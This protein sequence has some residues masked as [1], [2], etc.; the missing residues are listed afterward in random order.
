MKT[1]INIIPA[2][3]L[4]G[5]A[6]F[7]LAPVARAVSPAPDG[8]Y[9]GNNTAEGTLALFSRTTGIND[10]ALGFQ[11]LYHNTTGNYN[12][13]E[14]FRA[15]FT[16]TTGAVNTATGV[17]AL[18]SNSI[19]N[20]NTANGGNALYRNTSG[21]Q[22]TAIGVN[23]LFSTS[24][25]RYNTANGV[26]ALFHNT[27]GILNTAV[28]VGSL[29]NN[30]SG[31]G[32]IALG[33]N[34]G[35]NVTGSN[36]IAIGH[37]G[38]AGESGV[39]RIGTEGV[40]TDMFP[41][42]N[43]HIGSGPDAAF[44]IEP[45][46]GS[47]N[48]GYIR[49]GD[50]TGWRLHFGRSRQFSGGP[51]NTGTSGTLMTL[52]DNGNVGIGTLGL[53][54]APRTRLHVV[55]SSGSP[56]TPAGHIVFIQQNGGG[57]TAGLAIQTPVLGGALLLGDNFITFFDGNGTSVGAI[58]GNGSGSVQ[59]GGAGHD[60][61]EYLPK[62]DPAEEIVAAQVV[63]VRNGRIVSRGAAA[64][65]YMVVT[66]QA[67]VA[68]NRPSEDP[69]D[70]AKRSLVAFTGQVRVQVR[71][72]V[73]TGDFIVAS[74]NGDGTGVA[75][76]A[77]EIPPSAMHRVVGRAWESSSSEGLKTINVAVG[78]DQTSLAVPM[79]ERLACEN[80]ELRAANAALE[81]KLSD[82]DEKLTA[83]EARDQAREARL[84]RFENALA[85]RFAH[86]VTD[87]VA[88]RK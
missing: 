46:D 60:Y 5:I 79:L 21:V 50:N 53:V 52:Q 33:G 56:A 44:R 87:A 23:A 65:Q 7:A 26:N 3:M 69:T 14:G 19:G 4:F 88:D 27:T 34:A 83:L 61:A 35:L 45:S 80:K 59:L 73:K 43:I 1:N 30:S 68:G 2:L 20:Y 71:G 67:I 78:L 85:N 84:T 57:T 12:S 18:F 54:G 66:G 72:Q 22:N 38:I 31:S 17:N 49:F 55:G 10:T 36:N 64:D 41:A 29:L 13:A 48:A 40:H 75:M 16:N 74:E 32:N 77:A 47:P 24:T 9:P 76:A 58:E 63:G 37:A 86:S 15:L 70:L 42:G 62:E 11:A 39:I 25:G 51:L 28:G 8:G 81:K 6:W 82:Y